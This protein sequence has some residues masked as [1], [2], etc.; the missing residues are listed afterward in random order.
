MDFTEACFLPQNDEHPPFGKYKVVIVKRLLC[1]ATGNVLQ[2][3]HAL[4]VGS[5]QIFG[6]FCKIIVVEIV[7]YS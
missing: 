1:V 2:A 4:I 6:T 3:L 7:N 5:K